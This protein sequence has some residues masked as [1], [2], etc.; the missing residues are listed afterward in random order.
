MRIMEEGEFVT[1]A[2]AAEEKGVTR[3]TAYRA[4]REGKLAVVI[5]LGRR[6]VRRDALAAWQPSSVG[7]KRPGQGRKK[8][9]EVSQDTE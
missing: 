5:L 1:V 6:L 3:A 8:K 4:I 7:G 2:Q 9:T